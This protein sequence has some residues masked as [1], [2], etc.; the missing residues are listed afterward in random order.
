MHVSFALLNIWKVECN[1]E[2]MRIETS[3]ASI[4]I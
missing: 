2:Q 3:H 4:D 1:M